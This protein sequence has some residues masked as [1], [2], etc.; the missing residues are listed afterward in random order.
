ML[1]GGGVTVPALPRK[2]APAPFTRL[3][4]ALENAVVPPPLASRKPA[5]YVRV[6]TEEQ[7]VGQ[8]LGRLRPICPGA[9][10]YVDDGISGRSADRPSF[11]ALRSA[12]EAGFISE[13]YTVKLD[14][15]GRSVRDV[16]AFFDLCDVRGTRIVVVDQGFDTGTPGG[17]L[18]RTLLAAI[19]EFESELIRD[20][21]QAAMNAF[22][23]G[24]RRTKSGRPPGRPRRMTP[25][26]AARI[27]EL[28]AKGLQWKAIAKVVHMPAGSCSKVPKPK[29]EET[30]R[31]EKGPPEFGE[32]DVNRTSNPS[33]SPALGDAPP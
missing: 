16:L 26:V 2:G 15:L 5:L 20:R 31:S 18:T 12:V 6:S 30:P 27:L 3:K 25:E 9:Q 13:V 33:P 14:R 28:R 24:T 32:T 22:K 8:Q 11:N 29:P 17:R 1:G 23:A 4:D 10:E 21:T 7:S 19:A